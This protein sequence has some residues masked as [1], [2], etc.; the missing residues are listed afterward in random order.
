MQ[1]HSIELGSVRLPDGHPRSADRTCPIRCFVVPHP[2]GVVLIDTGPRQGHPVIDE[3]YAPVV[4]PIVEALHTIGVDERQVTAIVNTHLHFDHC[5]QNAALPGASVW[6][7]DDELA[8]AAEP[9]YTVPEWAEI[10]PGRRRRADDGV[11]IVDG[12]RLLQTPGHTPGHL[13]VTVET[14]AGLEVVAGQV[15]YCAAEFDGNGPTAGDLHGSEWADAA[16]DSWRR[17]RALEPVAVH[18]S[19]DRTVWRP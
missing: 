19:H 7:T 12:V 3:L 10:D 5:G 18:F 13:S 8:A 2:D 9:F 16:A 14:A 4:E 1:I 11:E 6:V 17:L 15:C